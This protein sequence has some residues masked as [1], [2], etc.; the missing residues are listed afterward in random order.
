MLKSKSKELFNLF[1]VEYPRKQ[2]KKK[3]FI[4]WDKLKLYDI[5]DKLIEDV[6]KR[7]DSDPQWRNKQ[8]VPLATTYFNGE[9]WEDEIIKETID[10][11]VRSMDIMSLGKDKGILPRAGES[12]ESYERRVRNTRC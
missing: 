11:P 5:A 12:M 6:K 1:W 10:K 4:T 9:R 3:A 2:D 8:Y 7:K